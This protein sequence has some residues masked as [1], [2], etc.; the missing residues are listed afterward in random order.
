MILREI[1]AKTECFCM[2]LMEIYKL[3]PCD[4]KVTRGRRERRQICVR[5]VCL[6]PREVNDFVSQPIILET[7]CVLGLSRWVFVL[8][9]DY[10]KDICIT[11]KRM[12][13]LV[14]PKYY[15]IVEI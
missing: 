13:Y 11:Y 10:F 5:G 4:R 3:F 7:V 15:H 2:Q 9:F 6:S 8:L 14:G 12:L 1:Y